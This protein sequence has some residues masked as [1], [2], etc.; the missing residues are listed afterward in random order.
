MFPYNYF[1]HKTKVLFDGINYEVKFFASKNRLNLIL[2]LY[3]FNK[4]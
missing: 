4:K 3:F 1:P 2:Y